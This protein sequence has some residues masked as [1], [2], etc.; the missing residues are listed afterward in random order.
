MRRGFFVSSS[1]EVSADGTTGKGLWLMAGLESGLTEPAEAANIPLSSHLFAE[2]SAHMLTVT[3]TARQ[4]SCL[5]TVAL[6][7]ASNS[8]T[9]GA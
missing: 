8:S 1:G 5:M 4:G 2:A 6:N 3:P 7:G 9:R